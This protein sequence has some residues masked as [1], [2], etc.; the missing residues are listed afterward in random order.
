TGSLQTYAPS[1]GIYYDR[2]QSQAWRFTQSS[3]GSRTITMTPTGGQDFWVE[4]LGPG[5]IWADSIG[6][7][8]G[9]RSFTTGNLPIGV[10]AVRVRAGNTTATGT[11]GYTL[12]VQ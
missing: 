3:V 7:A 12:S 2:N 4:V 6:G 1:L 11:F 10:Y 9:T 5:G 8:T